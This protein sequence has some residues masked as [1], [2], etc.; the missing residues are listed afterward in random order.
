M[1]SWKMRWVLPSAVFCSKR[2]ISRIWRGLVKRKTPSPLRPRV[3]LS[4]R[5]RPS[6]VAMYLLSTGNLARTVLGMGILCLARIWTP[7]SLSSAD[8]IAE[9]L[10][11]ILTP[12]F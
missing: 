11:M 1:H 12:M 9:A 7:R 4:T 3:V 6:W 5:G 8:S 10:F 2:V